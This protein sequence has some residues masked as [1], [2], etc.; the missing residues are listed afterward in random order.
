MNFNDVGMS[1]YI[2]KMGSQVEYSIEEMGRMITMHRDRYVISTQN[3]I[4]EENYEHY[5][6][7]QRKM[8]HFSR[9]EQDQTR[10]SKHLSR[11]IKDMKRFNDKY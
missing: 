8:N 11:V 5:L 1:H 3:G 6:K 10:N 9:S 2:R 7:L 4:A